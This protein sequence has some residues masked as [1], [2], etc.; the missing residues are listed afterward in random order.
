[1]WEYYH[2]GSVLD[3]V[4]WI[5]LVAGSGLGILYYIWEY[6]DKKKNPKKYDEIYNFDWKKGLEEE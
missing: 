1:M 5:G 4:I 6:F 2:E 3:V